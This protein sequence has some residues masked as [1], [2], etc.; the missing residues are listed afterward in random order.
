MAQLGDRAR[1]G[2]ALHRWWSKE[3]ERRAGPM[4]ARCGAAVLPGDGMETM[5]A[6]LSEL[7]RFCLGG[8]DRP[9]L[10]HSDTDGD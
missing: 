4:C 7:S 6:K 1:T 10:V 5:L 2:R 9:L 3:S 8:D